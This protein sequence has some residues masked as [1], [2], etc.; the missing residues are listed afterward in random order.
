MPGAVGD[1]PGSS[2]AGVPLVRVLW[3]RGPGPPLLPASK[4]R[5]GAG[6]DIVASIN[7]GRCLSCLGVDRPLCRALS[8][9]RSGA[10]HPSLGYAESPGDPQRSPFPACPQ[11]PA[12][13]VVGGVAP[14][15]LRVWAVPVPSSPGHFSAHLP[16]KGSEKSQSQEACATFLVKNFPNLTLGPLSHGVKL[17]L[18]GAH[19][20]NPVTCQTGLFDQGMVVN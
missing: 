19:V 5:F 7:H 9:C 11:L 6:G 15:C 16:M 12:P 2:N 1:S 20:R 17:G 4:D 10:G 18:Q 3:A 8:P 14:T 13:V